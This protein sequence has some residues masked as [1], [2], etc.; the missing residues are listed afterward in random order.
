MAADEM[1][2]AWRLPEAGHAGTCRWRFRCGYTR[3]NRAQCGGKWNF[4]GRM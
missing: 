1:A 3:A 4:Q 2:A